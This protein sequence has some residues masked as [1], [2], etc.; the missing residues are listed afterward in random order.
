MGTMFLQVV[1]AS[2][3]VA[4]LRDFTPLAAQL[5]PIELGL[6]LSRFYEHVGAIVERHRGRVVKFLGD[7][8]LTVFVGSGNRKHALDALAEL[9]RAREPFLDENVNRKLPV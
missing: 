3:V 7:G 5:G 4:D 6:A 8:V 2:V 1:E 9:L